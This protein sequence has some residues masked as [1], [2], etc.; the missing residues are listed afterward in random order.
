MGFG[1]N[2]LTFLV[3]K[4]ISLN[5]ENIP[6]SVSVKKPYERAILDCRTGTELR[7]T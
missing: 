5:I 3:G 4:G 2:V 1:Q 7:L 6:K